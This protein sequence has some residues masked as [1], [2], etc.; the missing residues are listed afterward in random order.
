MKKSFLIIL[1]LFIFTG[2]ADRVS[3]A[4]TVSP[5]ETDH[6]IINAPSGIKAGEPFTI[7]L[8]VRDFYDNM[9]AGYDQKE[10]EIEIKAIGTGEFK[11]G[12]IKSDDF[13]EGK[14]VVTCSYSRAEI[15]KIIVKEKGSAALGSAILQAFPG[16]AAYFEIMLPAQSRAGEPFTGEIIARDAN[17]NCVTSFG[18][19]QGSI[20]IT[21]NGESTVSPNYLNQT[22]FTEGI[23]AIKLTCTKTGKATLVF[24]NE[25]G[26][27][28]GTGTMGIKPGFIHHFSIAYP[29]EITAG[30]AFQTEITAK[31]A[32]DNVCVYYDKEGKGVFIKTSGTGLIKPEFIPAFSFQNGAATINF[33]YTK[34][35]PITIAA[36]E[37]SEVKIKAKEVSEE[38]AAVKTPKPKVVIPPPAPKP[39]FDQEKRISELKNQASAYINA[40]QY[41]KAMETTDGILK[42]DPTDK[43]AVRLKERLEQVIR[44]LQ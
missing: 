28:S 32:Y 39:V 3:A 30:R 34:A 37:N 18:T 24:K 16:K 25:A 41:E 31:D 8:E 17:G 12:I 10:K 38:P 26:K 5:G 4:I 1:S 19:E 14:T 44:I 7:E 6:F 36:Q 2:T 23:A 40:G 27:I 33:I 42:L 13:K 21:N 22:N 15:F 9:I 43:D 20:R 11:P 35:E 29:S